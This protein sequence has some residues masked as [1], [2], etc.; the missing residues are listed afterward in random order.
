MTVTSKG[1]AGAL[2]SAAPTPYARMTGIGGYR[3]RRFVPISDIVE[4]IDS[5]YEWIRERS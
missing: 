3:P 2:R 1:F 4:R 5:S